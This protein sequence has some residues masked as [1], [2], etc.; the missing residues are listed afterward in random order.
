MNFA[1]TTG[2]GEIPEGGPRTCSFFITTGQRTGRAIS[3][4]FIIQ[5]IHSFI[6]SC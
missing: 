1:T 4:E 2:D 6:H 3:V 5:Y